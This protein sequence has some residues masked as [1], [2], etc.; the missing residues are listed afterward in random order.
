MQQGAAAAATTAAAAAAAGALFVPAQELAGQ[1]GCLK[2]RF[3]LIHSC[4]TLSPDNVLLVMCL[5]HN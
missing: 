4:H 1:V 3:Q 2:V 5:E